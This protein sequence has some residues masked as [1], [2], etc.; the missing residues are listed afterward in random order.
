MDIKLEMKKLGQRAKDASAELA[1]ASANQKQKALENAANCIW[2][3]RKDI[4][5]E[6]NNDLIFAKDKDL[7]D[8]MIDRLLLDETR[9][10]AMVDGLQFYCC[11]K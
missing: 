7:S 8:A 9:I 1:S 2:D 3:K 5:S 4:L 10:Q 6:N 11:P